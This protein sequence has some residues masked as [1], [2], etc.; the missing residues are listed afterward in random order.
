MTTQEARQELRTNKDYVSMTIIKETGDII[1]NTRNSVIK[2]LQK[3]N[4]EL[5]KQVQTITVHNSIRFN[6]QN[7]NRYK[8]ELKI[9]NLEKKLEL[10]RNNRDWDRIEKQIQKLKNDCNEQTN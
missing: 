5:K 2:R 6:N 10:V 7:I 3:E 8:K 1:F 9:E 4:R